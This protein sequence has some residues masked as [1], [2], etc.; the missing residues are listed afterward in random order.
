MKWRYACPSA[1]YTWCILYIGVMDVIEIMYIVIMSGIVHKV[2]YSIWMDS[3]V[4]DACIHSGQQLY[5]CSR[6]K[7]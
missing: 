4:H 1:E 5:I 2:C 3:K 7:R 6:N